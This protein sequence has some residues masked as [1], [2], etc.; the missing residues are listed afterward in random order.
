CDHAH[1]LALFESADW[2]ARQRA[3]L[4]AVA[5]PHAD[6]LLAQMLGEAP[7][8]ESVLI[9]GALGETQGPSGVIALRL[10]VAATGPR[11]R[12][13]RCVALLGLAK[14]LG[15]D[16]SPDLS[17]ALA[18]RDAVVKHYAL[19]GLAGAGN[20]DAIAPVVNRL[21][22][23]AGKRSPWAEATDV[24]LSVAY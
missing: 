3:I 19:I 18:S 12:D 23:V 13:L 21:R 17:A 20:G 5:D 16:A 4:V 2:R 9:A 15:P 11:T 7:R 8:S 6:V 24:L 10:A 22:T 14:R 1:V